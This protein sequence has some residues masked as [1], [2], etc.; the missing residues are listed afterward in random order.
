[1]LFEVQSNK[2][3][4]SLEKNN[5]KLIVVGPVQAADTKNQ[6]GRSYPREILEREVKNY[7]ATFVK[8]RR[9]LGELDHP[10][11]S[12]VTLGNTSHN[13]LDVW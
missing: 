6:N 5:G 1:M 12:I 9:A 3:N 7:N 2:I 8:E 13:V 4:E 10:E 11:S